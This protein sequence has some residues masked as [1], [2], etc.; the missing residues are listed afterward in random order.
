MFVSKFEDCEEFVSGDKAVLRELLS[1]VT[2]PLDLRYSLAHAKLAPGS[3][4]LPHRLESSEVYYIIQGTGL[5]SIEDEKKVVGPTDTIYI[6]PREIQFITN[7]GED[8]LIFLAIVDPAWE[9]KDEEI[10]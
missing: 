1:P 3:A 4:T 9:E 7:I 8:E 2:A 5:M 10:L 6:P